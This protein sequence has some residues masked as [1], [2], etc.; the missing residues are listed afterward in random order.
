VLD[1]GAPDWS[2]ER[3]HDPLRLE[4]PIAQVRDFVAAIRSRDPT[5][6]APS[7]HALAGRWAVLQVEAARRSAAEGTLVALPPAP[8]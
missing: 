1:A 4:A 2:I 8:G 6:T 7:D 5:A 3:R